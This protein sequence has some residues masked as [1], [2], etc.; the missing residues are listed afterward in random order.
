MV[1]TK[2]NEVQVLTFLLVLH[3]KPIGDRKSW[4]FATCKFS[5]SGPQKPIGDR[6]SCVF[7]TCKVRPSGTQKPIGD[8]KSWVLHDLQS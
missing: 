4:V 2:E 5:P 1:K 7:T 3:A 8:R 6:K